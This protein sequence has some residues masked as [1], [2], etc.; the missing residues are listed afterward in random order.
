MRLTK[1][2]GVTG[3]VLGLGF[4]GSV[5]AGDANATADEVKAKVQEAA[6]ALQ[7]GDLSDFNTDGKWNPENKWV[8]KDTYVFVYDCDADK[9]LAH[10]TLAVEGKT[11]MGIKDKAGK[12]LFVALCEAGKQ[13]NGGWVS[14]MWPKKGE[15]DPSQ[16]V[17]YALQVEGQSFQ[18]SSGIYSDDANVEELNAALAK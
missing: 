17:S 6:A 16:K 12:E 5:F 15:T 7:S 11:I 2:I 4:S 8:W 18:V 14:Y 9:A 3:L 10:P 13:A 1:L